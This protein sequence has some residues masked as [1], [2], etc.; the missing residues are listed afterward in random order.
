[1][2]DLEG[3][4]RECREGNLLRVARREL[5]GFLRLEREWW[6]ERIREIGEM[7]KILR[8]VETRWKKVP[9]GEKLTADEFRKEFENIS[10]ER[11]KRRAGDQGK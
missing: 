1:M 10:R 4:L 11:Y 9:A 8:K 5:K 6:E 3:E 2:A 7:Y